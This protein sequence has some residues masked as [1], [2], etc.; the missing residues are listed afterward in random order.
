M[1]ASIDPHAPAFGRKDYFRVLEIPESC[2][3]ARSKLGQWYFESR[4]AQA[5]RSSQSKQKHDKTIQIKTER[6]R[7]RPFLL[8]IEKW[9]SLRI[10]GA[11]DG[12]RDLPLLSSLKKFKGMEPVQASGNQVSNRLGQIHWVAHLAL[13]KEMVD[14]QIWV[15]QPRRIAARLSRRVAALRLRGL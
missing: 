11:M 3:K 9:L 5:R 15:I 10:L 7:L 1:E 2:D 4:F 13:P 12:L 14:G 8:L 6:P